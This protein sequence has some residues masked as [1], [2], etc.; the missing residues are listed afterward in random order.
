M[1]RKTSSGPF[2]VYLQTVL[3]ARLINV[4]RTS[5]SAGKTLLWRRC[6]FSGKARWFVIY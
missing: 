6:N 4:Q 2:F 1:G 3:G 5:E